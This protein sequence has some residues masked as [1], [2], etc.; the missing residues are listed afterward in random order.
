MP[1]GRPDPA[2]PNILVGIRLPAD[3]G[4]LVEMAYTFA[5]EFAALGHDR[6]RILRMFRNPRF[7]GPHA[8]YRALGEGIV[9]GIVAECVRVFGHTRVVLE[10]AKLVKG[11]GRLASWRED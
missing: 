4:G 9:L 7:G 5:E 2:D 3:E 8:A 1:H 11:G 6:D 10:D